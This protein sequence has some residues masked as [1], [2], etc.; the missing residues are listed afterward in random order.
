VIYTRLVR[1][2]PFATIV[3][4]AGKDRSQG[5]IS[6][7]PRRRAGTI[8]CESDGTLAVAARTLPR[9][10]SATVLL[11]SGQIATATVLSFNAN[12]RD[13]WGGVYFNVLRSR[14]VRRAVLVERDQSRR[15]LRHLLLTPVG[16]CV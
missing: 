8:T 15:V 10:Q 12:D 4:D 7:S 14:A 3:V 9:A 5:C 1:C 6:A 11:S 2:S 13:R 16:N